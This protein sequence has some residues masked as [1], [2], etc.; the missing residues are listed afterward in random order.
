MENERSGSEGRRREQ[1]MERAEKRRKE[2]GET[3][4]KKR[5]KRG[6]GRGG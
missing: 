6:R 3:W 2:E 4:V 5:E 1:S